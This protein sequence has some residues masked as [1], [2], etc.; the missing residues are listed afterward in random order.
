MVS[1]GW[2]VDECDPPPDGEEQ[3]DASD[4]D[5]IDAKED[6][7]SATSL[8]SKECTDTAAAVIR[9]ATTKSEITLVFSVSKSVSTTKG[10]VPSKPTRG[11]STV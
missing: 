5:D 9:D 4:I 11:W 7:S 2:S 3:D 10:V 8:E 1:D 6:S